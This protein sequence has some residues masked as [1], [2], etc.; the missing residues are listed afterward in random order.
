MSVP[1]HIPWRTSD[2]QDLLYLPYPCV[3]LAKPVGPFASV[4]LAAPP[5]LAPALAAAELS[6]NFV[7]ASLSLLNLSAFP[8]ILSGCTLSDS[9]LYAVRISACVAVTGTF[10]IYLIHDHQYAAFGAKEGRTR[11][12]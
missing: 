8:P 5:A 11:T 6:I 10:N 12:S 2:F 7:Y 1:C 9:F 4:L 3:S